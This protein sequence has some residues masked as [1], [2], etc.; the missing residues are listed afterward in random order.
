MGQKVEDLG[1]LDCSRPGH[2][3]NKLDDLR[4]EKKKPQ[5]CTPNILEVWSDKSLFDPAVKGAATEGQ[6][7]HN[8]SGRQERPLV[9]HKRVSRVAAGLQWGILPVPS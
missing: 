8:F 5:M 7:L 2:M 4:A 1:V 9:T 3:V 6:Q